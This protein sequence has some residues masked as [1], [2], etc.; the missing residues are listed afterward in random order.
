LPCK[1]GITTGCNYFALL[2]SLVVPASAKTCYAPTAAQAGI[3]LPAF[4]RS[5]PADGKEKNFLK[6]KPAPYLALTTGF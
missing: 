6:N 5:L 3:V 2:R 4:V 1:P